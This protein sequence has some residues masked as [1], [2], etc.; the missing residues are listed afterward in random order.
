MYRSVG[1]MLCV[2]LALL[3]NYSISAQ[4]PMRPPGWG[5]AVEI[6][7]ISPDK[8]KLQQILI[9]QERKIAVINS[10]VVKEGQSIAG[11]TIVKIEK[12][13]IR[14]RSGGVIKV[15]KLLP[16]MKGVNREL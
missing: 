15:I 8:I 16:T 7:S 2:A 3:G 1:V 10:K 5:R 4:D 11:A 14:I 12:N 6:N 13:Q 9:S